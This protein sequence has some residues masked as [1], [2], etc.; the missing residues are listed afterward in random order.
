[1]QEK[2]IENKI[3]YQIMEKK[4]EGNKRKK[5][6]KDGKYSNYG[7]THNSKELWKVIQNIFCNMACIL[8]LLHT[9]LIISSCLE[10]NCTTTLKQH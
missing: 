4:M 3:T 7:W 9:S 6:W 8:Q 5:V 1:L 10:N 2:A